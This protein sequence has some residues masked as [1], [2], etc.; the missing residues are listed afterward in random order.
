MAIAASLIWP[1][2]IQ[3]LED[4]LSETTNELIQIQLPTTFSSLTD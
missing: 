3:K 2:Y 4:R 1:N